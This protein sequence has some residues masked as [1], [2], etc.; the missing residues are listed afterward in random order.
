MSKATRAMYGPKPI[1]RTMPTPSG[2]TLGEDGFWKPSRNRWK[3]RYVYRRGMAR[4]L[5]NPRRER[6]S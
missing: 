4:F 6:V 2:A 5:P 1:P 3:R